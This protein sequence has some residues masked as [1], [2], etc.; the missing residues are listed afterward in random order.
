M[1]RQVD[2]LVTGYLKKWSGLGKSANTALL[3]LP[4]SLGGLNLPSPSTLYKRLQISRQC[5]LLTSQDSCM[6]FLADRGLKN[7]LSLSRK[8]FR[9]ALEAREALKVSPGCSRKALTKSA[10]VLVSEEV[11]SSRLDNLQSLGR[12]GQLSR[13]T[14]PSCAPIW[15]RAVLALTADQLKFAI[16]AAVDVLPHNANLY[17]WRKRKDALCPICHENQSLLHVLNNCSVATVS[18]RYNIRHD[19][20][21]SA[22]TETVSCNIPTT[23]SMTADISDTYDFPHHIIP[24]DLRPDLVWWDET[25]KSITL[26]EL[27]VCFE[28]NFV[29]AAR[30]KTAKYLHLVEQAKARGYR[31]ELITLQVGSRGVPDLPGFENLAGSLSLP[32]KDLVRLLESAASLALTGSFGIWCSRNKLQ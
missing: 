2:S 8:K 3:Y 28:T 12:Q 1:E 9:P 10:K 16:N 22:I 19:S 32:H 27:T 31:S 30:R 4:Q 14:S 20:I 29:E 7:E 21:L 26:V 17:L 11:N 5:Q 13:C 24:T 18:R 23:S 15:S 25:H 6:R